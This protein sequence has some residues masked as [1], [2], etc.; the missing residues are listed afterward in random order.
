MKLFFVAILTLEML[1]ICLSSLTGSEFR[2]KQKNEKCC[3]CCDGGGANKWRSNMMEGRL[4][5]AGEG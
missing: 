1:S 5:K 3:C 4:R 2:M